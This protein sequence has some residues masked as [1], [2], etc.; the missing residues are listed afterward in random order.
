MKRI[1]FF[2][3]GLISSGL[4]FAQSS[5]LSLI[6]EKAT[7]KTKNLYVFLGTLNKDQ[8]MFGHQDDIL[9]GL[10][11][12]YNLGSDVEL[13]SGNR[14]AVVGWDIGKLGQEVNI[15]SFRFEQIIKGIKYVYKKGGIN[16]ISWH[17]DNPLTGG[18]SWDKESGIGELLPGGS[19]HE[20]YLNK[21]DEL[22]RFIKKCKVGLFTKIPIIL[23]PFHEHNGDWFW[24]GKAFNK[25]EEYISLWRF[26]VDYLK[27]EKNLHNLIYA[28]SP[29]RS[30]ME[31]TWESYHYGYPGDNYVDIIGLDNYWDMGHPVNP[32]PSEEQL[33]DFANSIKLITNIA[34]KRNKLA[35]LTETG[36][37]TVKLPNWYT[38]RL[39][40]PLKSSNANLAWVLVWRNANKEHYFVPYKGHPNEED[41]IAFEQD[42]STLFLKDIRNPYKKSK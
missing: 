30:R 27:N 37:E 20:A 14:P 11:W 16:T 33:L 5:S 12:K 35:A 2:L 18:S 8:I 28:F 32:K 42:E 4:L 34:N 1:L 31:L 15:D 6:D 36:N 13:I 19:G 24:W 39:L 3:V 21:L 40:E 41:F 38:Q 26:T 25:E 22:A 29:D 10:D 7:R 23:R 17:M 9:Y